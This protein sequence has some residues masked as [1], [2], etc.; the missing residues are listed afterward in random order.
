MNDNEC[1]GCAE[2]ARCTAYVVCILGSFLIMAGMV[3]L[4]QYYTRPAPLNQKRAEERRKN[5]ADLKAANVEFLN[6]YGWMDQ[7]KGI[8]RL[9]V[10]RA[11]E[12]TVQ[13]LKN[14]AAFRSNLIA[15]VEKATALPPKAPEKPS[16]FE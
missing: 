11:M 15:Q 13:Q 4:M 16:I 9:P 1:C 2:K 12:L 5:L 7:P 10:S 8:V 6:N 3:W 14:P